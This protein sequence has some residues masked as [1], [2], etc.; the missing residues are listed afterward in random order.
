MTGPDGR[1]SPFPGYPAALRAEVDAL[2]GEGN[3][4]VEDASSLCA[5]Q[6]EA[7][8]EQLVA[9][10]RALWSRAGW[11]EREQRSSELSIRTSLQLLAGILRD[12]RH[13]GR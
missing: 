6:F 12:D 9:H 5:E 10:S 8:L 11:S 1:Y 3:A 2:A 7:R 13:G 4:L